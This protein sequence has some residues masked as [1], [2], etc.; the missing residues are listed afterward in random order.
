VSSSYFAFSQVSRNP[1]AKTITAST[2]ITEK[3]AVMLRL[4]SD[5]C[6]FD[7]TQTANSGAPVQMLIVHRAEAVTRPIFFSAIQP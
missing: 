7:P 1:R 5:P 3:T 2:P 6:T 4:P